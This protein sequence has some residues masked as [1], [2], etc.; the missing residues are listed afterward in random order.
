MGMVQAYLIHFNQKL[1]L[2]RPSYKCKKKIPMAQ[3]DPISLK[4]NTMFF[5]ETIG[6]GSKKQRFFICPFMNAWKNSFSHFIMNLKPLNCFI[7]C[8]QFK[9]VTL[10]QII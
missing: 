10:K 3:E 4:I 2:V 8:T 7:T 1:P 9:T 6:V 5:K